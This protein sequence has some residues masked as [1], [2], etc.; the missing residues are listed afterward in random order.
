MPV[1]ELLMVN[2]T[3]RVLLFR[4][5]GQYWENISINLL[6]IYLLTL[7]EDVSKQL[8]QI[9]LIEFFLFSPSSIWK[10]PFHYAIIAQSTYLIELLSS[11]DLEIDVNRYEFRAHFCGRFSK[12]VDRLTRVLCDSSCFFLRSCWYVDM[13]MFISVV[14]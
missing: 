7:R 10:F 14:L 3:R 4:L 8:P 12:G 13:S 9:E 11:I 6:V 5:G 1:C 2:S